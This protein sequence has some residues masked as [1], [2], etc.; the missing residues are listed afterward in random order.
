MHNNKRRHEEAESLFGMLQVIAIP[1]SLWE[2]QVGTEQQIALLRKAIQ[3]PPA[4]EVYHTLSLSIPRNLLGGTSLQFAPSRSDLGT[5]SQPLT[6]RRSS[7][8]DLPESRQMSPSFV[9]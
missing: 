5:S 8:V 9:R 1:V 2:F 3:D 4:I 7:E 6:S